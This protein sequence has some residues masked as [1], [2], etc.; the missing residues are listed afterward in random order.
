MPKRKY[1]AGI[2][3][4]QCGGYATSVAYT[5]LADGHVIRTRRCLSVGC[6]AELKT[7]ERILGSPPPDVEN[8]IGKQTQESLAQILQFI[9]E[10]N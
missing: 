5:H 6:G 7:I 9:K 8:A 10:R 3:C 4:L 2:R 1:T